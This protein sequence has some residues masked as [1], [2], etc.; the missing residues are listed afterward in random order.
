MNLSIRNRLLLGFGV[1]LV[2]LAVVAGVG[3]MQLAR[4]QHYNTE[5]DERAFRLSLASD[6][7]T[8][9]KLAV[10]TKSTVP[11]LSIEQVKKLGSL[12]QAP[13]EKQACQRQR[14]PM[15]PHPKSIRKP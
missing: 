4:I 8:Q 3:Q 7:A 10:A 9:V 12:T 11:A 13:D 5:L 2:L 14:T 1:I 6:W 15:Q